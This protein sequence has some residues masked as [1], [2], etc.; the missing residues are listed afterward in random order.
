RTEKRKVWRMVVQMPSAL[1]RGKRENDGWSGD[2]L[3][4]SRPAQATQPSAVNVPLLHDCL[5]VVVG[6]SQ[7]DEFFKE[8]AVWIYPWTEVDR[9]S[10]PL[11]LA[12]HCLLFHFQFLELHGTPSNPP[13]NSRALVCYLI[14]LD[15][16]GH[17]RRKRKGADRAI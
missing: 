5:R 3:L 6:I 15:E 11:D 2:D 12:P 14:D 4:H 7:S 13:I 17:S 8:R 9:G 16:Q 10:G 1:L